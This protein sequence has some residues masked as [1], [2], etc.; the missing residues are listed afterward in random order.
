MEESTNDLQ[1]QRSSWSLV[2]YALLGFLGVALI[3]GGMKF[4]SSPRVARAAVTLKASEGAVGKGPLDAPITIIEYADFE[5]PYCR[6]AAPA[7]QEVMDTYPQTVRVE[8]RHFPLFS[9]HARAMAV[10]LAAQCAHKQDKFWEFYKA[11]YAV[12]ADLGD[13]ALLRYARQAGVDIAKF[14]QCYVNKETLQAVTD[15]LSTGARLGV[16]GTPTFFINGEKLHGSP[17]FDQ[18]RAMIEPLSHE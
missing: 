2:R 15:D 4:F 18:W 16:D 12:P 13:G 17:T 8:Y 1:P 7:L 14:T 10:A 3:A 9:I 11:F 5:C 6:A